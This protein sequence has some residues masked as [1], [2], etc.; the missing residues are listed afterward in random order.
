MHGRAVHIFTIPGAIFFAV[1]V[2]G[3]VYAAFITGFGHAWGR[4]R[5]KVETFVETYGG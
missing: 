5:L 1:A 4:F 2:S 3:V